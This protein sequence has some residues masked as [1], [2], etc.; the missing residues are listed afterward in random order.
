MEG[1]FRRI[2]ILAAAG[3]VAA[4]ALS[5]CYVE[6]AYS[7]PYAGADVVVDA[8]PPPPQDEVIGVAPAPGYFWIGGFWGWEGGR[9]VWHGGHWQAP[10]SGY[11]WRPHAWVNEG[12][13]WHA[14]P[15]HWERR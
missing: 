2:S 10:R 1:K 15:G 3:F 4:A 14:H 8:P 12:G 11:A 7:G 13:H 5:G 6:P 9:H